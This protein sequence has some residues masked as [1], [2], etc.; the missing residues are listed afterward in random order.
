MSPTELLAI[1]MIA[2]FFVLLIIGIPVGIAIAVSGLV[3]GY[4]GFGPMLFNLLPARIYG[5]VTNYTFM[6]IPLF[7]FM[8]V[9]LEK[10]RLAEELIDIIGHVFGKVAGGMGVA[11][12]LVGVLLG[13]ATG[14]VGATIVTLG[15]LTLPTLLRRGY[16]KYL[17]TGMICASGTLGQIIPPSLVLILLAEILGESVGTMFAAAMIPGL[18]LAGVYI[19]AILVLAAWKPGLMPPIPQAERDAMSG[20]QLAKKVLLVVGPPIGLVIAVLGSIIG[21]LAAPTEAASMGAIGALAFVALSGRLTFDLLKQVARSTLL[22]SSMVF[23]ILICAQVF[24]LAFRGLGGEHLVGRMFEW[25]PGGVN[26][27][28]LFMLL[29]VFLLGFFLEWIEISYIALPLFLPF[30]IAN[31][32]DLVWLGILICLNLQTSFLTPPFGWSLFFLKGVAPPEVTTLDIYK[33]AVPFIGL[34]AL[35]LALV[36]VFPGLALWLPAAIGW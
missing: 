12:I 13:A 36:Y 31:G 10:S 33:G 5:V 6:A 32:V 22:I 25:V 29:L 21:G 34:Q 24:G 18:T 23:F 14:I 7:V 9:M 27:A 17:A 30:F 19:I 16:P 28:I 2:A 1:G 35:A 26:G 8:G 15:L 4:A 3:F 11:I 20:A